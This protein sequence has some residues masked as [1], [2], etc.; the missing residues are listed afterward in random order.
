V[1]SGANG[2]D[3]QPRCS[4]STSRIVLVDDQPLFRSALREL[5]HGRSELVVVGEAAEERE[6]LDLCRRLRPEVV[7]VA[8]RMP[9]MQGLATTRMLSQELPD[10]AVLVMT[11]EDPD[12]LCEAI[13]AGAA[14]HVLK[15]ASFKEIIE[16]VYRVA[17]GEA[18]LNQEIAL[19]LLRQ[20]LC[21][22]PEQTE[23]TTGLA[24]G[25]SAPPPLLLEALT[26]QEAAVLKLV[27]KGQTNQQIA[28]SL[29]ISTSTVKKH[30]H[31]II[32]KLGV[33]D[34]TQAA[35]KAI[36]LSLLDERDEQ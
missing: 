5:L 10:T 27:A 28:R 24:P 32:S 9:K 8:L 19:G 20:L 11:V 18:A 6:A 22:P 14:G 13:K 15:S 3:E 23:S 35:I 2:E 36:E 1:A 31:L 30:V 16:A 29:L 25:S 7:V 17:A 12:C 34:R 4:S 26:R 21:E 33:S